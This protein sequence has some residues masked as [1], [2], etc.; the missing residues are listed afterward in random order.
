MKR[1]GELHQER[2][3]KKKERDLQVGVVLIL[4]DGLRADSEVVPCRRRRIV[5]LEL[6]ETIRRGKSDVDKQK[7]AER[8][9][10]SIMSREVTT[11]GEAPKPFSKWILCTRLRGP[12]CCRHNS[13]S[14]RS[15]TAR[16]REYLMQVVSICL[17]LLEGLPAAYDLH[18]CTHSSACFHLWKKKKLEYSPDG[19]RL[20][21]SS[22]AI[23]LMSA[24]QTSVLRHVERV[25]VNPRVSGAP[26]AT[27]SRWSSSCSI[28][29]GRAG[30][31]NA[32]H[33]RK[34]K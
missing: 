6:R 10:R 12:E 25:R 18:I 9:S 27:L 20:Y 1:R 28:C 31:L 34:K 22:M 8:T 16:E 32:A 13:Q 14:T 17:V 15:V 23:Q 2:K 29:A 5:Y 4:V 11:A 3:K 26:V 24:D 33:E 19:Q 30:Y 7:E 21:E